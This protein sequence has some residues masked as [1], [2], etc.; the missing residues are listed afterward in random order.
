MTRF[1]ILIVLF[2]LGS[3]FPL[4]SSSVDVIEQSFSVAQHSFE[5][6]KNGTQALLDQHLK[7]YPYTPYFEEVHTMLGVLETEAGS[8]SRAKRTLSE[9]KRRRLS[10]PSQ[11]MLNFHLGYCCLM[12]EQFDECMGYFAPLTTVE[13]LYK[14]QATYYYAY[15]NYA[16]ER[17]DTALTYFLQI[18]HDTTYAN[19]VPY[20]IA[21]IYYMRH[22]LSQTQDRCETLLKQKNVVA[23]NTGEAYRMLGEINYASA[24]YKGAI[25]NLSSYQRLFSKQGKELVREDVYILGISHYHLKEYEDA[26]KY[27][28]MVKHAEDTISENTYLHLGH[29]Y[30]LTKNMGQAKMSY[31]SAYQIG[32]TPAIKE[33]AL[34]NYLLTS[35]PTTSALGEN[36]QAF[37]D[38]L[39]EFPESK[40]RDEIQEIMVNSLVGAT[41]YKEALSVLETI[42]DDS[43]KVHSTRLFLQYQ[44][45]TDAFAQNQYEVAKDYFTLVAKDSVESSYRTEALYW[46]SEIAYRMRN[47]DE[48]RVNINM[49]LQ[50]SNVFQSPN[51]IEADYLNGYVLFQ[52]NNFVESKDAFERYV[53]KVDRSK[54][55]YADALNRLG[56]CYYN[57]RDFDK[58]TGCYNK[59]IALQGTGADYATFQC[60]YSLGLM[61]QY[62]AKMN[63]MS[64]LVEN[65]PNSDYADDAL[66]EMARA[67]LENEEPVE[68]L[69]AYKKLFEQYP[70]SPLN[71]KASL[72]YAMTYYALKNYSQA[73]DAFKYTIEKYAGSDEAYLALEELQQI[74]VETNNINDYLEYSKTLPQLNMSVNI[75]SQEDSLTY[76]TAELQYMQGNY[77]VAVTGLTTYINL[78]CSG[79]RHCT[80]AQYYA[81]DCYYR[82]GRYEEALSHYEALSKIQGNPYMDETYRR[83]AELL[84]DKEDYQEAMIYFKKLQELATNNSEKHIA[85]LGLLRCSKNL[86]DN[87]STIDISTDLL[88]DNSIDDKIRTEAM[89]SRAKAYWSEK[90][91]GLAL[92]DLMLLSSDVRTT[93][94]AEAKYLLA[95]AYYNMN[96]LPKSEEE[97]MSFTKL[98]TQHQYWLAKSLILLVDIHIKKNDLFQAKQYLLS[99]QNNYKKDDDIKILVVQ[100]LQQIDVLESSA[101][102]DHSEPVTG[103]DS[104]LIEN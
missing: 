46:L 104:I 39:V 48:A 74:Y 38:F 53:D 24:D 16:L 84:F 14:P 23:E 73:I 47:Y 81:A 30:S 77:D 56:D 9:V 90:N 7:T 69:T 61:R 13:N 5:Q 76:I 40:H 25:K 98:T 89:Y 70:N 95:Q 57:A 55:T 88:S 51:V 44:L 6:R 65:Y 54:I 93:V 27:L 10:K 3:I 17:Y 64:S 97:I 37:K 80:S 67:A 36:L 100:K 91:Y 15:A 52:Q 60:G 4:F 103:G 63:K 58:A 94:G 82:L 31:Q 78:F 29:C 68:A 2:S 101:V 85:S 45:G 20:Y 35:Y 102:L 96:N 33:E 75:A 43:P 28:K 22:D 59:V 92:G 99:L 87:A 41:N 83:M 21:Q 34:Y 79:G 66:Y 12:Q 50:Q 19:T 42:E 32:L 1:Y 86:Q 26:I 11:A 49:F 71:C 62:R 8:Y 18:E 72:E